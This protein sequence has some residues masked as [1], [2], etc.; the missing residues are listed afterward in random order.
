MHFSLDRSTL[1]ML[2]Q[3]VLPAATNSSLP[4]HSCIRL[5][6]KS[7][8]LYLSATD[9]L[10]IGIKAFDACEVHEE[11]A[12]GVSA[13]ALA[14]IISNFPQGPLSAKLTGNRL[15]VKNKKAAIHLTTIP[16]EHFPVMPDYTAEFKECHG[17]FEAAKRVEFATS[18]AD[19]SRAWMSGVRFIN[20]RMV[21]TDGHRLA[22]VA[23]SHGLPPVT[24][25]ADLLKRAHKAIGDKASVGISDAHLHFKSEKVSLFVALLA[26]SYPDY[27]RIIPEDAHHD[28]T[29]DKAELVSALD[30][31]KSTADQ[32]DPAVTI[33]CL[34]GVM[35]LSSKSEGTE[36]YH[37][38]PAQFSTPVK[39]S[40]STKY[41]ADVLERLQSEKEVVF[42]FR[43][44]VRPLVIKEEG[45]VNI[46]MPKRPV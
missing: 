1:H 2:V 8:C 13:K 5:E 34:D 32:K 46:V 40:V 45:Y 12:L 10:S 29:V 23:Y 19:T 16:E 22:I 9:G 28:V 25:P 36:G 21:A 44:A 43:S 7:G 39:V 24:V 14:D 33:D 6:A 31:I 35:R 4:V 11:G 42:E 41:V 15:Q 17:F 30:L 3:K 20:D 26:G 37:E 27:Q 38:I 18:P